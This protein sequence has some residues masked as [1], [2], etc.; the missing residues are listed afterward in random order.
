MAS[1]STAPRDHLKYFVAGSSIAA[2]GSFGLRFGLVVIL[3]WIG[4]LKFTAYEAENIKGLVDNSPLMSWYSQVTDLQG[5]SKLIGV[6]EIVLG[7]MIATRYW[8]PL[9]SAIGSFLAIGMFLVT[10]SFV[11]TTPGVW[12]E[13]Y[14]FPYPSMTGQFLAK[15]ILSIGVAI[16]SAGEALAAAY[17]D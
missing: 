2:I 7:L 12:Q 5:F 16:W 6:I 1:G 8:L 11:L 13:G 15:D 3:L 10:L 9:I 17:Q 14:G 4:A